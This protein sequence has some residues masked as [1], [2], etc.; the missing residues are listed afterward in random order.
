VLAITSAPRLVCDDL[1]VREVR[2]MRWTGK[3]VPDV[4]DE[5][6]PGLE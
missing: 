3:D 1:P 2:P 6:R 4:L 5:A